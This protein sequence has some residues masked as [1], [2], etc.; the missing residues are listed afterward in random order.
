VN[1]DEVCE[2]LLRLPP[3][4]AVVLPPAV[5]R[6]TAETAIDKATGCNGALRFSIGEQFSPGTPLKPARR[7]V[8]IERLK[9]PGGH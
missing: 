1:S 7:Y 9:D 8:R 6:E 4:A 2:L 3:G 5:D